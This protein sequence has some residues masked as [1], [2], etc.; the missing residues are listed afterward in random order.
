MREAITLKEAA[1]E[2]VRERSEELLAVSHTISANPELSMQEFAS[3]ALLVDAV[4]SLTGV[5]AQTGTG[6]LE[7]AF[8]ATAGSGELKLTI[9]AEYDALPVVGHGCGH[10]IIATAALGAFV[11]LAPL[12][13]ELGMT[14]RLLGTPAEENGGGKVKLLDAGAFEGTHAAIMV[15]PAPLDNVSMNPYASNGLKVRF[16]GK[17]AHA[18]LAPHEGV[19][20][21]DAITV[22]MTAVGLARQQLKPGQQIHSSISEAGGAPNV[23]PGT[24]AAMWMVRGD[25]LDSLEEVTQVVERCINAGALAAACEV[26]IEKKTK[27]CYSNILLDHE[28]IEL[29]RENALHIGR[30]PADIAPLGGSTD[31]GNV[32]L[33]VPSIH[34]MIGLNNPELTLHTAEFAAAAAGPA[35]DAAALDG[36]ILLAQTAIDIATTAKVRERLLGPNPLAQTQ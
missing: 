26:T 22:A 24:A 10:N 20:A 28:L 30:T 16:I 31:M 5:T 34:P 23:I 21:L 36:A 18:S 32:S 19:N 33:V 7:T 25:S 4:A 11:A 2:S 12:A 6:G 1:Q 9:C 29:Y 13:D 17:E 15:H 8:Q 27:G 14:V 35:G 3:S